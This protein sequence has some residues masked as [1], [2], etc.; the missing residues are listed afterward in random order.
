MSLKEKGWNLVSIWS[1]AISKEEE[2][3]A[4]QEVK[5]KMGAMGV[6]MGMVRA[7]ARSTVKMLRGGGG[8][9]GRW[10]PGDQERAPGY[11]FN[12]TP[13]PPGQKRKWEDWEAPYYITG[14]LA[15]LILGVGL[16]AKPDTT[17]ETWAHKKAL[18]RLQQQQQDKEQELPL[19]NAE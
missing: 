2:G 12:R 3:S 8:A 10:G 15:V 16:N 9:G 13:L 18:E 7:R 6:C 11:L 4:G 19:A 17:I 14:V 5:L 1:G